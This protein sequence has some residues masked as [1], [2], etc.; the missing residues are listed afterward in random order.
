MNWNPI[1]TCSHFSNMSSVNWLLPS[2]RI[3]SCWCHR[4]QVQVFCYTVC[5]LSERQFRSQT[6]SDFLFHTF[7]CRF[8]LVE[9]VWMQHVWKIFCPINFLEKLRMRPPEMNS[10]L[11]WL[12]KQEINWQT[13]TLQKDKQGVLHV[14]RFDSRPEAKNDAFTTMIS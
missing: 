7:S 2:F 1:L 8:L 3:P 12:S 14:R 10:F 5:V 6:T 9:L 4:V 11:G 13:E